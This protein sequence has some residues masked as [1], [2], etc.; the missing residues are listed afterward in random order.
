KILLSNVFN[1]IK[2]TQPD[3]E[4]KKCV[5]RT[6]KSTKEEGVVMLEV[7]LHNRTITYEDFAQKVPPQVTA[8]TVSRRPGEDHLAKWMAMEREHLDEETA[9]KRL[10]WALAHRDWA[11]EMWRKRAMRGY[12]VTVERAGGE[13][14]VSQMMTGCFY[15]QKYGLFLPFFPDP[16]CVGGGV[17]SRSIIQ[18]YNQYDFIS[19]WE[20]IKREIGEE[21]IFLIIDNARTHLP[22]TRCL[23]SKG[24]NLKQ[25]TPYLPDLNPIEYIWSLMKAI[26]H[27]Y[28]PELYLM[29]GPKDD[30]RKVIKEA[31]T[32]CWELLDPKVFDD[33]TGS[34]V[35]RTKAIIEAD[36]WYI[37]Y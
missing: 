13:R 27:K 21:E 25:I 16:N 23:K 28:Y 19:I 18:I 30:V 7:A 12:E 32:F 22:F 24:I 37:R 4:E 14:K 6:K 3:G 26:L 9:K 10:E 31:V 29:R 11:R 2:K 8:Y 34:M 20:E 35:D 17:T 5:G 33:L 36:G 15:G 1:T